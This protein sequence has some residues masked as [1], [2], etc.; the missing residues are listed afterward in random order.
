MEKLLVT[1]ND[2]NGLYVAMKS[3]DDN[4]IVGVGDIPEKA[5][6]DAEMK[7]FKNPV[8]LYIPEEDVVHI[9]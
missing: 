1:T 9:Y 5:L 2:Y 4:T 3:F 7:G 6:E 8:I